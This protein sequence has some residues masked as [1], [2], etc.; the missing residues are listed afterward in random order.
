MTGAGDVFVWSETDGSEEC[1]S[2]RIVSSAITN[3][4]DTWLPCGDD[5]CPMA[6]MLKIKSENKI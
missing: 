2:Y 6:G 1:D 3:D 5:E 4:V